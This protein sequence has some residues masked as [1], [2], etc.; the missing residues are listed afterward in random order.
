MLYATHNSRVKPVKASLLPNLTISLP[1][2]TFIPSYASYIRAVALATG[3][4]TGRVYWKLCNYI[5]FQIR[6]RLHLRVCMSQT[7][8]FLDHIF[9]QKKLPDHIVYCKV[10]EPLLQL[11]K[12]TRLWILRR[13]AI[14]IE[15]GNCLVSVGIQRC[16]PVLLDAWWHISVQF[17]VCFILEWITDAYNFQNLPSVTPVK[18]KKQ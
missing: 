3:H 5:A 6:C 13:T 4:S 8:H 12:C 1:Y 7:G 11:L 16:S 15:M 14:L 10:K 18:N 17:A 2:L 9:L